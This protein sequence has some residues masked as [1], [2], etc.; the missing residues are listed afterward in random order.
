[1]QAKVAMAAVSGVIFLKLVLLKLALH[2]MDA[3]IL[4][5]DMFAPPVIAVAGMAVF[6]WVCWVTWRLG[7]ADSDVRG[8]LKVLLAL[9]AFLFLMLM[10]IE[11]LPSGSL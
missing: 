8:L 4:A 1:M 2:G 7:K 3:F 10:F 9:D 6:A 11:Y 5:R